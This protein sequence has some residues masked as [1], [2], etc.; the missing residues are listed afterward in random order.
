MRPRKK[1]A[2]NFSDEAKN[3]V[4][5]ALSMLRL[6]STPDQT[7]EAWRQEQRAHHQIKRA[8]AVA[9]KRLNTSAVV[10]FQHWIAKTLAEQNRSMMRL[11][12]NLT[13]L[14][15]L[16]SELTSQNFS[17]E[18]RIAADQLKRQ[19]PALSAF[20]KDVEAFQTELLRKDWDGAKAILNSVISRH[21][22]SYWSIESSLG[23]EQAAGGME[24]LKARVT[25]LTISASGANR[26]LIYNF[27]I[28]NEPAQTSARFKINLKKRIDE[29]DLSTG[30]KTYF[31]YRL[32]GDVDLED[33]RIADVLA[34]EQLTSTIDLYFTVEKI[35][36]LVENKS[37]AFS[38]TVL[39]AAEAASVVL[40]QLTTN[41][42]VVTSRS[43]RLEALAAAALFNLTKSETQDVVATLDEMSGLV[44]DGLMSRLST[45]SDGVWGEDLAKAQLN[46]STVP[47]LSQ[48]GDTSEIPSLPALLLKASS[49][50]AATRNTPATIVA[51]LLNQIGLLFA[52]NND[53]LSQSATL[54]L[55]SEALNEQ[56]AGRSEVAVELLLGSIKDGPSVVSDDAYLVVAAHIQQQSGDL[57]GCIDTTAWAGMRS[58]KLLPILPFSELF[59][60]AKWVSLRK[61]GPSIELAI[62]LHLCLKTVDDRKL[63]TFKR[64]AVEELLKKYNCDSV[65]D[66]I[67]C[68]IQNER[69]LNRIEYFSYYVCDMYTMELLPGMADSRKVQLER[70]K[71]LRMLTGLQSSREL[72]YLEEAEMIDELL[73]V[74]DGL[75]VLDDSKVYVDEAA[76]LNFVNN[77]LAADFQRYLKLVEGGLGAADSFA[78]ILQNIKGFS[79]KSFQIPKNDADDLF[80]ELVATIRERFLFD[81]ASGLD[82]IVGR[83][84]RHGTIQAELRGQLEAVGLIGQRPRVGASYVPPDKVVSACSHLELKKTKIV[85]AA[86]SRFSESI[87]QLVT[88]LR[89]EYFH[90]NSKS[91]SRGIFEIQITAVTLALARSVAQTC[92][93][94]EDFSKQCLAIFWFLL[95]FRVSAARP[96]VEAE[97]KK[98]LASTFSKLTN[99]LRSVGIEDLSLF[100]DIQKA[101]EELQ[102]RASTIASWIRVPKVSMEGNTYSMR[103]VVDV[104]VATVIGQRAGFAPIVESDVPD[105]LALDTHGFSIVVDALYIALDNIY[106]HSGKKINNKVSIA[107]K[108]NKETSLISFTVINELAPNAKTPEKE[109]RLNAIRADIHKRIFGE[110]ARLDKG[111]GLSKLAALVMQSDSTKISFFY[112][113]ESKFQLHFDLVFV[114]AG[115]RHPSEKNTQKQRLPGIASDYEL[116]VEA[117]G[118]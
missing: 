44:M 18:L 101:S 22:Y 52:G 57:I 31:K 78:S 28:R 69:D 23:L 82:I 108:F 2:R 39:A 35:T 59:Q 105:D 109:V 30:L 5:G 67:A 36:R 79:T 100:S 103:Q 14:G 64:Y 90:V 65:V 72:I 37:E 11:G 66:L 16:P 111:S 60:S 73:S 53:L 20:L 46:F 88:L 118:E 74:N 54:R 77:E 9:K 50:G 102:R 17:T 107:A 29:S 106:Q 43:A 61:L 1:K 48:L 89:D 117:E 70:A 92:S 42:A 84:I 58:D 8:I 94:I 99:E 41:I 47:K 76:V 3:L 71:I 63:R 55:L 104:S 96:T 75:D 40:A 4:R 62:C 49:E 98:T 91:K 26:F 32:Y 27:G 86:F 19:E 97:T 68:L 34:C 93:S 12:T 15:L 114:G 33:S 25:D 87:D 112:N 13:T 56:K 81:P 83:R 113:E 80:A 115:A 21:G 6:I 85:F 38:P 51:G 24:A 116:S 95:S 110:R 7:F 45:Q 10:E